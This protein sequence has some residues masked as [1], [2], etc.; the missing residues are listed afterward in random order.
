[1]LKRGVAA[2][3]MKETLEHESFDKLRTGYTKN[4]RIARRKGLKTSYPQIALIYTD[5][6][7]FRRG[8]PVW[9]PFVSFSGS[10]GESIAPPRARKKLC[11]TT[12]FTD[13]ADYK[14]KSNR[15]GHSAAKPQP[16]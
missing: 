4:S 3:K 8:G 9:P 15:G 7:W 2:P 5:Y 16:K 11:L 6:D 10:T 12:D 13:C 14:K 1:M